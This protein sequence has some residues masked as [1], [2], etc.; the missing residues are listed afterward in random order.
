MSQNISWEHQIDGQTYF[1]IYERV[2]GNPVLTVNG[3][4]IP[5]K[6]GFFSTMVGFDEAFM[7]DGK[8]ARLVIEKKIPKIIVNDRYLENNKQYIPRPAWVIVF[9]VLCLLMPVISFGG[10]FPLLLG[11]LG[12]GLCFSVSKSPLHTALRVLFCTLITI[13]AWILWF[14]LIFG[15]S[16]IV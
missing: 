4:V 7:L 10:L 12:T 2:K 9:A 3:S 1:F 6:P 13:G 11:L 15:A 5:I 14:I 16:M 8:P